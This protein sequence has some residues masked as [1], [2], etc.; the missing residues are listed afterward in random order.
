MLQYQV[1]NKK[2]IQNEY[3]VGSYA[4]RCEGSRLDMVVVGNER[5]HERGIVI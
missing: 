4:E 5:K 1:I 3:G 2:G